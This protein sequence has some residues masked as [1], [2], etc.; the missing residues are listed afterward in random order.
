MEKT[1]DFIKDKFEY[2]FGQHSGVADKRTRSVDVSGD[3]F[4]RRRYP[5]Q[6]DAHDRLPVPRDRRR[7][8]QRP[9]CASDRAAIQQ[10]SSYHIYASPIAR[11]SARTSE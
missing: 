6:P 11:S 9:R 3:L 1:K 8:H 2:A 7:L 4:V 10:P 5:Q